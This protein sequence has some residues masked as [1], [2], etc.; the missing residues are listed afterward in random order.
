MEEDIDTEEQLEEYL[1]S[2]AVLSK[3]QAEYM[4]LRQKR[5][6]FDVSSLIRWKISI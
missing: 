5:V 6:S 1:S 4:Y 3:P 2:D